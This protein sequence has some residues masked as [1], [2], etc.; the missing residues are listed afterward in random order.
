M[1]EGIIEV[2]T[3]DEHHVLILL[4]TIEV[5][6][7]V[8]NLS[9]DRNGDIYAAAFPQLYKLSESAS[10]PFNI[11]AP[12]AVIR[13]RKGKGREGVVLHGELGDLEV[14]TVL[15]DDGTVVGGATIAVH[16]AETGRI[17]TGGVVVPFINVC[18][19]W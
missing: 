1:T 3:L 17:F 6:Y 11:K 13:I 18:E 5:P 8:D 10:D 15:E 9:V 4:D 16:D 19:T 2:F 12:S 14:E 7:P